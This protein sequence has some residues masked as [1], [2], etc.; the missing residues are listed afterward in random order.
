MSVC[1]QLKPQEGL[2]W[3]YR[4]SFAIY[5]DQLEHAKTCLDKSLTL[6]D[7]TWPRCLAY[8]SLADVEVRQNRPEK[9]LGYI[10]KALLLEYRGP[11]SAWLRVSKVQ[12]LLRLQ[13]A[14]D[15]RAEARRI[16]EINYI[17]TNHFA[18]AVLGD[19]VA[20]EKSIKEWLAGFGESTRLRFEKRMASRAYLAVGRFDQA[21]ELRFQSLNQGVPPR[22]DAYR[23]PETLS[24]AIE[25]CC[26]YPGN[27]ICHSFLGEVHYRQG[28]HQNALDEL[29][30]AIEDH[31]EGGMAREYFLLAMVHAELDQ[32]ENA[33]T[34][35]EKGVEWMKANCPEDGQ[36]ESL[37][38]EAA[39][40]FGAGERLPKETDEPGG[41]TPENS[42]GTQQESANA[43]SSGDTASPPGP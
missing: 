9:A 43:E 41:T 35:Y 10:E 38:R 20:V 19:A 1:T 4:G 31:A 6:L 12:C 2:A 28:D 16:L 3:L 18:Y 15:A 26:E 5:L 37:R 30:Q 8:R 24:M 23:S 25:A 7:N 42:G 21:I 17:G 33:R 29:S 36:I 13:R 32:T 34:W 11:E 22:D 39:K 27:P 40:L 14:A